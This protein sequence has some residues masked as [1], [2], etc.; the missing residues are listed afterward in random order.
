MS[1][2]NCDGLMTSPPTPGDDFE[3]AFEG[4]PPELNAAFALGDENFER[5]FTASDGLG[6][7]FNNTG[8]VSCHPGDGRG[9]VDE[10]LIRFSL[11]GNL[12]LAQGGPQLQDKAI[13][14]VPVEVLPV[15]VQSSP[16]LPPP[17]FGV[18]LIE[19][20]P[21]QAILA[22]ADSSDVNADG[23]SGRPN[24]VL[25][26]PFVP[27]TD[28]GGGEGL[29]LG[30]FGRKANVSSLLQQVVEAYHQ[31][32]GITSDF[33]PQENPNPQTGGVAIGD[34]IDDPEISASTV[35]QTTVYVRLLAPPRRGAITP[36]V[37]L[38]EQVFEDIGCAGCHVPSLLTGPNAITPLDQV[39][40]ELYSDLLLHDM[41]PGL[42]DNR[43]DGLAT[44]T[45]W[46]TAPLWGT[47]LVGDFLNGNEF[48]LHDGRAT[49]L[50]AAIQ[51]HGGEAKLSRDNYI[52]LTDERRAALLEFLRSL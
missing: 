38:G 52:T 18:G 27:A 29:Q 3:S 36:Q 44:G 11:N 32:I 33:I 23:I 1:L 24:W 21:V 6:P 26:A 15:G 2:V 5:V 8:C 4:L 16:R 46:K 47:R 25:S 14:G 51:W 48:F 9:S 49:T 13:S 45:E 42:A 12:L 17:V 40:V 35:L 39:N 28:V 43:P 41:G 20:I 34:N 50:D 10:V 22:N 31:D 30:R 37:E 7:I 19:A